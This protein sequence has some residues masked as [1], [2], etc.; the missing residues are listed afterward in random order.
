[1]EPKYLAF[2]FGASTPLAHHLTFDDYRIPREITTTMGFIHI[3]EKQHESRKKP[4]YEY[5]LLYWLVNRDP[6][7]E[8]FIIIPI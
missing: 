1:M 5:F 8:W 2:R 7:I 3:P 4:S 6:Y